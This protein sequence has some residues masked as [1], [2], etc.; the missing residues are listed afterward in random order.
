MKFKK[1]GADVVSWLIKNKLAKSREEGV[2][3][4]KW[5]RSLNIFRHVASNDEGFQD[6]SRTFYSFYV[7]NTYLF[8]F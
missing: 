6:S 1:K 2:K 5:L 7:K 8:F 3:I 4:G